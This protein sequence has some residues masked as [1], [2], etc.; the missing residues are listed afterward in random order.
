MDIVRAMGLETG[1]SGGVQMLRTR[2]NKAME[3]EVFVLA[4]QRLSK[5]F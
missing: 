3:T 5:K 1:S 2:T 4:E